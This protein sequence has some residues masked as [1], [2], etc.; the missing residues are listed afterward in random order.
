[1]TTV[2]HQ[3]VGER[4]PTG[5]GKQDDPE[6]DPVEATRVCRSGK[7][8]FSLYACARTAT[9]DRWR[10]NRHVYRRVHY[11]PIGYSRLGAPT[12]ET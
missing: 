1:M 7:V 10:R 5:V 12:V 3:T 11:V 6:G 4:G 2:L 9:D 8:Y